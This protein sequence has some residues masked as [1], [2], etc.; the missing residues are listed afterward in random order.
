MRKFLSLLCAVTLLATCIIS[1]P[2]SASTTFPLTIAF[3]GTTTSVDAEWGG[4]THPGILVPAGWNWEATGRAS[5]CDKTTK[6]SNGYARARIFT[7]SGDVKMMAVSGGDIAFTK[8][9]D[10]DPGYEYTVSSEVLFKATTGNLGG[11]ID[12]AVGYL[13]SNGDFVALKTAYSKKDVDDLTCGTVVSTGYGNLYPSSMSVPITADGVSA[14]VMKIAFS[15]ADE[16][17]GPEDYAFAKSFTITKGDAV[18]VLVASAEITDKVEVTTQPDTT[19]TITKNSRSYSVT[20][21]AT[22]DAEAIGDSGNTASSNGLRLYTYS[23]NERMLWTKGP[24]L[25]FYRYVEVEPG[26]EYTVDANLLLNFNSDDDTDVKGATL[27][28][29]LYNKDANGTY[30]AII[31][32]NSV[33]TVKVDKKAREL[34]F[35]AAVSTGY[36]T[37]YPTEISASIAADTANANVIKVSYNGYSFSHLNSMATRGFEVYRGRKVTFVPA[38]DRDVTVTYNLGT[39]G[40]ILTDTITLAIGAAGKASLRPVTAN[41]TKV[42]SA[43]G[44]FKGWK[45]GETSTVYTSEEGKKAPVGASD[46]ALTL[47]ALWYAVENNV[48]S[49]AQAQK[50]TLS[51]GKNVIRFLALVDDSYVDYK[52][53][54]FVF[55]TLAQNPT[56]EAGYT[57]YGFNEVYGKI[58]AAGQVLDVTDSTFLAKF[59]NK[60]TELNPTAIIYA[61]VVIKSGDENTVYYATPYVE[62]A[63]GTREYGQ[64]KAISYAQLAALDVQ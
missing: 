37:M 36:E 7:Y 15:G 17:M 31:N 38:V 1:V 60:G 64:S 54:G 53:V 41:G 33:K 56:I 3:D 11:R 16:V 43:T 13:D 39:N 47:N 50:A 45:L 49:G 62:K 25:S 44:Y 24:D 18:P 58:N 20:V 40:G 22:W 29:S 2:A 9:I 30:T 35:G 14:N 8:F 63:D 52:E 6:L 23:G 34:D 55:T 57:K 12:V 51:D 5:W 19:K 10:I 28:L 42:V 46:S 21:P 27:T 61:N 4:Y 32:P 59:Q 48:V 26:Y